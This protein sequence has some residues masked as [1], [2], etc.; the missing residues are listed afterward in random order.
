[1]RPNR[2][3]INI[4]PQTQIELDWAKDAERMILYAD[5][6][7][8]SDKVCSSNYNKV[9]HEL[10]DFKKKFNK[11]MSTFTQGGNMR[12]VQFSDS[13]LIVVNGIEYKHFNI[14]SKAAVCLMQIA[15]SKKLPIKGIIAQGI[16]MYNKDEE[17]YLGRPLVDAAK[18][19]E[20]IKY[21]GIVVHHSA[22]IT[23]RNY[24]DE[25]NPYTETPIMTSSG[26]VQYYYLCWNLLNSS[27]SHKDITEDCVKWTKEIALSVSGPA[28]RYVDST[29][30]IL[31]NDSSAYS[32]E[33]TKA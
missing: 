13:I 9:K 1:M 28:R 12:F 2:K 22:E 33:D 16:F 8:F 25:Q 19:Y 29:I 5:L 23:I 24:S 7:G 31:R 32:I 10:I 14:L 18:L 3:K 21:Y 11:R 15:M 6:M 20:D 27:L 30:E 26:K 17:L 4:Q